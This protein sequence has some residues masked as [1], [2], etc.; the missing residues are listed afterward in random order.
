[1][2]SGGYVG[3]DDAVSLIDAYRFLRATEH[4]L[5]LRRLRRTHVLPEEPEQLLWLG[6]AMGYRPDR[7][8]D[9]R[10][11]FEAEWNLHAREVRR[12]HEKLFYRPLL[13]AVAR[14]PSDGLRLTP[15]E[16]R[17]AAG[18]LGF[19]DPPAALRHIESL[20]GGLSRRAALQ[21]ALLPVLLSDFADAPDPDAGL[22]AYRRLSDELGSTPWYLR[23]LRDGDAVASRLAYVLGTQPLRRPHARPLARGP[24]DARVDRD[25]LSPAGAGRGRGRHGRVGRPT[26]RPGRRG[27]RRARRAP[28]GTAAHRLRRPAR[29][30]AT[31]TRCAPR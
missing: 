6:R 12:L 23:L 13:E 26:G 10:A 20:T 19:A 9:A 29:A 4:R 28:A 5:Q 14:V 25:S 3:R 15:D 24:A 11:V 1:M 31:S 27:R 16:A 22:L 30:S 7:R 21:R 17:P 2:R 8:G 18:A